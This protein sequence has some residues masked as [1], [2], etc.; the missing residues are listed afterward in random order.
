[1]TTQAPS[2][3]PASYES[4]FFSALML[5]R[6]LIRV[7]VDRDS[8]GNH[9]STPDRPTDSGEQAIVGRRERVT[10]SGFGSGPAAR[11]A[12]ILGVL[13][14]AGVSVGALTGAER[15]DA[16]PI[17]RAQLTQSCPNCKDPSGAVNFTTGTFV[18]GTPEHLNQHLF[19]GQTGQVRQRMLAD[20][21]PGPTVEVQGR[22]ISI[23]GQLGLL[24]ES[25][26]IAQTFDEFAS[27]SGGILSEALASF[28]V[29]N[30]IVN[31]PVPAG[32]RVPVQLNL[33]IRGQM[34]VDALPRDRAGFGSIGS[35][36][37]LQL[38]VAM[39][40]R[41]H[42]GIL[43]LDL[44]QISNGPSF[45]SLGVPIDGTGFFEGLESQAEIE[46]SIHPLTGL[47]LVPFVRLPISLDL[48]LDFDVPANSPFAIDVAGFA[49]TFTN[50][51]LGFRGPWN[52]RAEALV[53]FV[54]TVSFPADGPV[55]NLPSGFTFNS[56]DG[57]VIDNRWL[58]GDVPPPSTPLEVAAP[59]AWLLVG[60]GL[61]SLALRRGRARPG[62]A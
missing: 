51:T 21:V 50:F 61:I 48:V 36:A 62:P 49:Q 25:S 55:L 56:A 11:V 15:A 52:H 30:N 59:P 12:M 39:A 20:L 2:R 8:S 44:S 58:G 41:R 54:N 29:D 6:W 22:A 7:A 53:D 16:A 14:L 9:E 4:G 28:R 35:F 24:A 3:P 43:A 40:G 47:R 45:P 37:R 27:T 60:L 42:G 57:Q 34:A 17:L 19:M 13:A 10:S 18:S 23:P 26:F 38:D 33:P 1:M 31:G 32:T 46:D 5:R